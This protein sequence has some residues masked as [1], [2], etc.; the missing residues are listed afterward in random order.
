MVLPKDITPEQLQRDSSLLLHSP[1]DIAGS[2]FLSNIKHYIVDLIYRTQ[3]CRRSSR[4]R[5]P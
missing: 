4:G 5:R 2:N 1:P 3:G